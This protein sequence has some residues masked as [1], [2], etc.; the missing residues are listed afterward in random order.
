MISGTKCDG[1]SNCDDSS[2]E[3]NCKEEYKD[4][5]LIPRPAEYKCTSPIY[6][7]KVNIST[8]AVKCDGVSECW[9]GLDESDCH[10]YSDTVLTILYMGEFF[11]R[12]DSV[13]MI[14]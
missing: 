2:D 10:P 1:Y 9:E 7:E 11:G 12:L 4:K 13:Y 3:E 6:G 8:W 14:N 5:K